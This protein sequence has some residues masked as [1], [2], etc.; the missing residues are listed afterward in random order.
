MP[1]ID[2]NH[3]LADRSDP[4]D[5][6]RQPQCPVQPPGRS[7]SGLRRAA[8]PDRGH[9]PVLWALNQKRVA[10]FL[11]V[12]F[13][14][15]DCAFTDPGHHGTPAQRMRAAQFGF[16]VADRAQK[17]G[18]ILPSDEFHDLFVAAYPSFIAP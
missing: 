14:I 6:R 15:G 1:C 8:V 10:Q 3:R 9:T 4:R 7:G 11:Q 13:N 5:S 2:A 18:H 12:F 17:Q 16:N